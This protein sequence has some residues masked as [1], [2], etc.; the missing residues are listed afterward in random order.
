MDEHLVIHDDG[1]NEGKGQVVNLTIYSMDDPSSNAEVELLVDTGSFLTW[2]SDGTLRRLGIKPRRRG[3]FK[4]IEGRTVERDVGIIGL[5]Y[6][7]EEAFAE[8]VFATA[9]DAQVLGVT[10]LEGLGYRVNPVT[11]KLEYIGLLAFLGLHR[12]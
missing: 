5:K 3:R 2:I 1:I 4:T 7:G 12:L 9:E 6:G 10:A 8:A 11:A